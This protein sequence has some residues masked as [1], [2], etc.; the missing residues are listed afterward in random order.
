MKISFHLIFK[1][2]K[3]L[4]WKREAVTH[5]IRSWMSEYRSVSINARR[6]SK[7]LLEGWVSE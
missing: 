4:G 7:R 5:G 3:M 2:D 1:V 6:W